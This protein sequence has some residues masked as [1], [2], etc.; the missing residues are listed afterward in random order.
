MLTEKSDQQFLKWFLLLFVG[1]RAM[2]T[3]GVGEERV[4]RRPDS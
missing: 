4:Q 3:I 1:G 2:V